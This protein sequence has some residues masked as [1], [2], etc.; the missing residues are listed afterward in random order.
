[1]VAAG[2]PTPSRPGNLSLP[3]YSAKP[4]MW[5]FLA[6]WRFVQTG[7]PETTALGNVIDYAEN[8]STG[9]LDV[10]NVLNVRLRDQWPRECK[11]FL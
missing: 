5:A 4:E 9:V 8:C 7:K 1:M 10:A 11:P 6:P 3:R 2:W